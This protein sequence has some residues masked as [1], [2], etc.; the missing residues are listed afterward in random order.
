MKKAFLSLGTNI[1]DKKKNLSRA[2]RYVNV[3]I[4]HIIDLSGI[5]ESEPWGFES[6]DT[7]LNMV[8]EI[9]TDLTP[10][11][12]IKK[13]LEI[14]EKLG[15]IRSK[16]EGYSSRIID[17]DILLFDKEIITEPD[18]SIPHPLM[19]SR[20]F[21]LEP[22]SEIAPDFVHPVLGENIKDLLAKCP[23]QTQVTQLSSMINGI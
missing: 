12:C 1:G 4:G 10:M 3:G 11:E 15:R 2:I 18:L 17:I 6:Q 23:D 14:E 22:L 5:Y 7:F 19:Q 9:I 13:C 21:V 16:D 20:K 8:I